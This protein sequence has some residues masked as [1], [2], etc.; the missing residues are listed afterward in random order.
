MRKAPFTDAGWKGGRLG[1]EETGGLFPPARV[2]LPAGNGKEKEAPPAQ[3]HRGL[4][5]ADGLNEPG[6]RFSSEPP[7]KAHPYQYLISPLGGPPR[8]QLDRTLRQYRRGVSHQYICGDL[9]GK[10]MEHKH[11]V[12]DFGEEEELLRLMYPSRICFRK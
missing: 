11:P 4:N 10:P 6:K 9:S 5:S 1:D 3:D 2:R 7:D 12:L 8:L